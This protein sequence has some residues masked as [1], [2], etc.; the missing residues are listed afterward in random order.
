ME[1]ANQKI[2]CIINP[3]DKYTLEQDY[4]YKLADEIGTVGG[5]QANFLTP[6]E[7]DKKKQNGEIVL[8]DNEVHQGDV[9]I[10][11]G[12]HAYAILRNKKSFQDLLSEKVVAINHIAY[13]LGCTS[14]EA[15]NSISYKFDSSYNSTNKSSLNAN[16]P[17]DAGN[18]P[19]NID[20]SEQLSLQMG[21]SVLGEV[22]LASKWK[23]KLTEESYAEAIRFAKEY[24][25]LND[26]QI[27]TLIEQRNPQKPSYIEERHY[28]INISSDLTLGIQMSN[29]IDGGLQNIMDLHLNLSDDLKAEEHKVYKFEFDAAFANLREETDVNQSENNINPAPPQQ[30]NDSIQRLEKK[31]EALVQQIEIQRQLL[32]NSLGTLSTSL[33]DRLEDI[34]SVLNNANEEINTLKIQLQLNDD[35]I[36]HQSKYLTEQIASL[37]SICQSAEI[38]VVNLT[39]SVDE[40]KQLY[41]G[42]LQKLS[43]EFKRKL[44]VLQEELSKHIDEVDTKLKAE[45]NDI[46]SENA[47]QIEKLNGQTNQLKQKIESEHIV[48]S[49][50]I[51]DLEAKQKAEL[52]ELEND[53]K[54]KLNQV[55]GQIDLLDQKIESKHTALTQILADSEVKLKA[56]LSE[57]EKDFNIKLNQVNGQIDLLD[58]KIE[59][60]KSDLQDTLNS[61]IL[62]CKQLLQDMDEQFYKQ[63]KKQK[64]VFYATSATIGAISI[65]SLMLTL[66]LL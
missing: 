2:Y 57:L 43:E 21:N 7:L 61:K 31:S 12:Q 63:S 42:K 25:L 56:E 10:S 65:A 20:D 32:D 13:L 6:Y 24:N 27:K 60:T 54:I 41:E 50:M 62:E 44:C 9:I 53:Y 22:K 33:N 4:A 37:S 48:L 1:T 11:L 26:L 51:T 34:K 40:S 58:Q 64:I 18:I 5:S 52:S 59:K 30:Y 55:S 14:F 15:K 3:D 35:K 8:K 38:K 49:Q 46:N 17:T 23:G 66:I 45:I 16:I 28:S 39:K 36:Q 29:K 19:V 47:K